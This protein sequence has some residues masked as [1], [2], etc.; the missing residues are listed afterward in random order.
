M[1]E[2]GMDEVRNDMKKMSQLNPAH[3]IKDEI[4][5]TFSDKPKP[6]STEKPVSEPAA[7]PS[8]S[9]APPSEGD[10]LGQSDAPTPAEPAR[11]DT[12]D[13]PVPA[14]EH[15]RTERETEG[16]QTPVRS[17]SANGSAGTERPAPAKDAVN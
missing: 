8:E 1:R 10:I 11:G 12:A 13:E 3:Q 6:A 7:K 15:Q 2:A 14:S 17:R 5:S 4:E 9:A 16:G